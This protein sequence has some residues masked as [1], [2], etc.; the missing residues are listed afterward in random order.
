MSQGTRERIIQ[1]GAEAMHR[2]GFQG[3]G[4]TEVL[5]AAGAPK[6]S[7]YHYFP[8]KEAFGLAV[9]DYYEEW[10]GG[11]ARAA[12]QTPGLTALERLQALVARFAEFFADRE[13]SLGCPIG[14]LAQEMGD[15]SE[16]FQK[17]LAAG[18][19]PMAAVMGEIIVAGQA[20][21]EFDPGLDAREAAAFLLAG[22]QGTLLRMKLTRSAE[23]LFLFERFA[24]R[25]LRLPGA[26]A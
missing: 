25:L 1:A 2:K 20:S 23:P 16:Q 12:L 21:G 17:R 9:L 14:K 5:R 6:G 8:S 11:V 22:W 3:T 19:S 26:V 4:L 13:Y 24:A 10:I 15:V 18:P 7:F